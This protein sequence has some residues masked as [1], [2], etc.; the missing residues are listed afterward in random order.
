MM[1]MMKMVMMN[2]LMMMVMG[3][4]TVIVVMVALMMTTV[5]TMNN[6]MMLLMMMLLML[7]MMMLVPH[8][9]NFLLSRTRRAWRL[10]NLRK[11]SMQCLRSQLPLSCS[12]SSRMMIWDG[13]A[14]NGLWVKG[15][16]PVD[17]IPFIDWA[18]PASK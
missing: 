4:V 13:T 2:M 1:M 15:V 10:W 5:T 7:L 17:P 14:K 12:C 6:T 18:S 3:M 11:R 8:N 16:L 9:Y